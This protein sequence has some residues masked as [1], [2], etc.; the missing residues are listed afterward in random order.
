MIG[1]EKLLKKLESVLAHSTADQTEIVY[2][3]DEFGL[4]RFANSFIH[5]NVY[6]NNCRVLFRS[7]LG[8]RVGVASTNSLV[9]AD[10]KQT[11]DNSIEIARSRAENPKF[12]GL[13]KGSKYKQL[14]TFDKA[15]ARCT[16]MQRAKTVQKVIAEATKNGFTIAGAYSTS[17]GEIAIVNSRGVRAYQP[18]TAAS[19]N[20]VTM[21]DT[22]SGYASVVSRRISNIDFKALAKTAVD[23]CKLSQNP[24]ALEPGEYEVILEPA[25]VAEVMEWL[26]YTGFG[27]KSFQQGR[28]FLAGRIGRKITS[29]K[30]TVYDNALDPKAIAFPFD[31]E[32]VSKKKVMLIDKGIARGVVYDSMAAIKGKTKSTGH[33]LPATEA[34]E[35]ALGLNIVVAP[36]K[37]PRAK[38]I[39]GVKRGILVTRFHYINGLIDTRNSV[40]T[41]MTRDGTFLIENGEIK[42]GI[43]N[44]RFTDSMM[45]AFK[46]TV[47]VSKE[48]QLVA[49]W[50]SGVGCVSVPTIH[51]GSFKFSGKT[52]F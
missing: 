41:G 26:N 51:L 16:P 2:I 20:M 44:L 21:S 49:A 11:L 24:Q 33:A 39:S 35:G 1:K 12:P 3:G 31:F 18:I 9:D 50:W 13:P 48:S 36:G 27:S 5:Q 42:Y 30:I 29:D 34:A 52:E 22:S 28:S 4:T 47:A 25:A 43:K 14:T 45:R 8:K 7:V 38:M 15:T 46:S 32:G 40:L 19:I 6:E 17:S 23:K 10:L 37:T